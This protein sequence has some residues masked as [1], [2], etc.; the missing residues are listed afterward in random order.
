MLSQTNTRRTAT[1]RFYI[2]LA[3]GL[4]GLLALV[5]RPSV[6][7]ET[8]LMA[9]NIVAILGIFLNCVWFITIRS[10]RHLAIVQRT[11]LKVM[12]KLLPYAFITRQ[13][14]MMQQSSGW[15]NTGNIEQHLPL[16]MMIPAVLILVVTNLG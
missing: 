1:V 2:S 10:L 4:V 14:Q 7:A 9:T 3:S 6:D 11:L 16:A 12:E 8:Q 13:E 15:L 5:H